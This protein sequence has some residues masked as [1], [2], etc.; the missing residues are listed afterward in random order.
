MPKAFPSFDIFEHE[1]VPKHEILSEE[2]K[3]QILA[4]YKVQPYQLPQISSSDPAAKA[5]GAKPG[6]ILRIVRKS[7]TAGKHY[8]YRYVID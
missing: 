3:Q 5:V 7:P 1:L 6:D 8:A 2:E 4:Q